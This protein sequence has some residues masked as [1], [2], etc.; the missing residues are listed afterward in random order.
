MHNKFSSY[1]LN[2][3]AICTYVGLLGAVFFIDIQYWAICFIML[4]VVAFGA[5]IFNLQRMQAISEIPISTI[6]SAAQGY[7][8]LMGKTESL[9]PLK[10]PLK[11]I[12]C[13]W[14]RYWVYAKNV[15][16]IWQLVDYKLSH[17][18]FGLRDDSGYCEINLEGAEMIAA[19]RYTM[20]NNAHKYIEDVLPVGQQIYVLGELDVRNNINVPEQIRQEVRELM[21]DWKT[22]LVKTMLR[23]DLNRD[24]QIDLN[25]WEFARQ[26]AYA[27]VTMRHKVLAENDVWVLAKPKNNRL[28]LVSGISPESLRSNYRYWSWLHGLSLF[29]A[30]L[31][32]ATLSVKHLL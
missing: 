13:V 24:G 32:L 22:N 7:V 26:Q 23:F 2:P 4:T 8:E 5:W 1:Y 11:S 29:T 14:F 19:Q 15:T 27:E 21:M 16:G 17:N 6:A 31:V 30:T 9:Q 20:T 25:E 10:S 28:Y 18:Q 12:D 3:V